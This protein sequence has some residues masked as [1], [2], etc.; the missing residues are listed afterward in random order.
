MGSPKGGWDHQ[1]CCNY[2]RRGRQQQVFG[3]P[4]GNASRPP[5]GARVNQEQLDFFEKRQVGHATDRLVQG[6]NNRS[7]HNNPTS[8]TTASTTDPT[9][10]TMI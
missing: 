7:A 1:H 6:V 2:Q 3:Q 4:E 10:P 9:V 8:I 5:P